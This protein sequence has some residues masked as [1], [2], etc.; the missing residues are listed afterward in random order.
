MFKFGF[1]IEDVDDTEDLLH[2]G[3]APNNTRDQS[4]AGAPLVVLEPFS[5]ISLKD[6]LDTIP[7][8]ISYSPLSIPL[9][10]PRKAT[11]LIRRDLFDARFQLISEGAG[12]ATDDAYQEE[13]ALAFLDAPSDLVPGVYEGGLKTWECSLDLVDYLDSLKDASV[14]S[15]KTFVGK[16]VLEVGCGTGV[17]SSYIFREVLSCTRTT[18]IS[19]DPSPRT[20]IHLQ[21]YNVSVLQ[22]VTLPNILLTWYTSPHADAYRSATGDQE[23]APTVDPTDAGELPITAELKDAFLSSL[24]AL[25]IS[26]RFFSGSWDTFDPI[27]TIGPAGYDILLTSETIYRTDSLDPLVNLMQVACTG[28]KKTGLQL[29]NLMSSRLTLEEDEPRYLCLVAA[30]ILYFGVGGGV[31]DFLK[32]VKDRNGQVETVLER[33]AGVGRKIMRVDWL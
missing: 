15:P 28:E 12:D 27:K 19:G 9:S 7:A 13:Q 22:L 2:L 31:S 1:D 26:F 16:K 20:E 25:K 5:E 17:P 21:D 18:A 23:V 33:K 29:E 8:L 6:L 14:P 30:K 3:E 32:T 4:S 10:S 24:S 11:T